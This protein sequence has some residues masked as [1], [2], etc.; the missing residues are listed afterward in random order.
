MNTR[1]GK[2]KA[3][4]ATKREAPMR[5][6]QLEAAAPAAPAPAEQLGKTSKLGRALRVTDVGKPEPPRV[7][8]AVTAAALTVAAAA[9]AG[10]EPKA[11]AT[12]STAPPAA[13]VVA[14]K[15]AAAKPAPTKSIAPTEHTA[16]VAATQAKARPSSAGAAI[17]VSASESKLTVPQPPQFKTD[18]RS[19]PKPKSTEELQLEAIAAAAAAIKA[20]PANRKVLESAGDMGVPRVQRPKPTQVQEFRLSASSRPAPPAP[21][22]EPPKAIAAMRGPPAVAS[23]TTKASVGQTKR[24]DDKAAEASAPERPHTARPRMQSTEPPAVASKTTAAS[25]LGESRNGPASLNPTERPATSEELELAA[26][27]QE[28]KLIKARSEKWRKQLAAVLADTGSKLPARSTTQLTIPHE[29]HFHS[30]SRSAP[31]SPAASPRGE[32]PGAATLA[33]QVAAFSKT[34]KRFRSLGPNEKPTPSPAASAPWVPTVPIEVELA[35]A[36]RAGRAPKPKSREELDEEMMASI[37]AFKARPVNR[38][39]IDSAGDFGVPRVQRAAPTQVQE[40]HLSASNATPKPAAKDAS[41]ASDGAEGSVAKP[42]KARPY[43]KAIMEGKATGLTQSTP[44]KATQPKTPHFRLVEREAMRPHCAADPSPE[45]ASFKA[46]PMPTFSPASAGDKSS[47]PATPRGVT[48]VVPFHLSGEMRHTSVEEARQRALEAQAEEERRARNFKARKMPV[49]EAWMPQHVE[50]PPVETKP[51]NFHYEERAALQASRLEQQR[52][53]EES[54]QK[55]A[56]EVHA[57]PVPHALEH[58]FAPAKSTKPLT[59]I[60]GFSERTSARAEERKQWEAQMATE[61]VGREAEMHKREIEEHERILAELAEIRAMA[62]FRARPAKV[63][64]TKPFE[65]VRGTAEPTKPHS[66]DLSS[67]RRFGPP[68]RVEAS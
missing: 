56:R 24:A 2:K 31:T 13:K 9:T 33:E 39:V 53:E 50:A 68:R 11:T 30:S 4:T 59:E 12:K 67:T 62:A 47:A 40:F 55:R 18:A 44:R 60:H 65:V 32:R 43:N 52:L 57:R 27:L 46:R 14:T 8:A 28:M 54:E 38:K 19:R 17:S 21:E 61:R 26:A 41:S 25:R 34:P 16:G 66:P 29:F 36:A 23:K 49:G 48:E 37:K 15:P 6:P 7:A 42:F 10:A 20:R 64:K 3:A 58:P 22:P 5:Q 63:L 35:S 45:F 1:S 51:F